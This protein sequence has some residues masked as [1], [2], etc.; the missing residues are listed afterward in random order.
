MKARSLECDVSNT[1]CGCVLDL[2]DAEQPWDDMK[3]T[4][5]RNF[6]VENGVDGI[7][8]FK[9]FSLLNGTHTSCF[10]AVGQRG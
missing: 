3:I 1:L 6:L 8:S 10:F 4:L 5:S 2:P 9:N 7:L